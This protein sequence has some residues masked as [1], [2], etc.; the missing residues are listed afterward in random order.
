MLDSAARAD[1]PTQRTISS[2]SSASSFRPFLDDAFHAVTLLTRR[3]DFEKL[4]RFLQAFNLS[5]SLFEVRLKRGSESCLFEPLAIFG[6]AF[7][8]CFSADIN[9]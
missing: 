1:I 4:R 8:S 5:F 9:P 3:L 2:P 6:I 7:V